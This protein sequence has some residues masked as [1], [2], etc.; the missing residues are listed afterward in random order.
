MYFGWSEESADLVLEKQVPGMVI[1]DIGWVDATKLDDVGYYVIISVVYM[2]YF[3]SIT[4]YTMS[5]HIRVISRSGCSATWALLTL[6]TLVA[7]AGDN[8]GK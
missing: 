1:A 6:S 4:V 8:L 2:K 3:S 7:K 5:C